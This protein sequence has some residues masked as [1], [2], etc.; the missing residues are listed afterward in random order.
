MRILL[1]GAT[2]VIGGQAVPVLAAAGHQVVGLARTPTRLPDAEVVA[3][4]A[5]DPA[6]VAKAIRAASPEVIVHMLS[7]IPDPAD[8]VRPR[9]RRRAEHG[10][11]GHRGRGAGAAAGPPL[12]P[13]LQLRSRR[14]RPH[15]TA[16]RRQ[17]PADR[18]RLAVLLRPRPRRGV[19]AWLAR[20]LLGGWGVAYMTGLAGASNAHARHLLDWNWTGSP[21]TPAGEPASPPTSPSGLPDENRNAPPTL[22]DVDRQPRWQDRGGKE[23]AHDRP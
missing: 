13:G 15:P 17:A 4:D 21:P 7:A 2:G 18:R 5:L 20:L 10:T 8:P 19:P 22:N 23:D 16:P 12:R 14:R 11:P 3:A 6:A 1:A 9:G